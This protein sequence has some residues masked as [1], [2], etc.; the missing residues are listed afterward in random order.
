MADKPYEASAFEFARLAIGS[1]IT[2]C[3]GALI[4]LMAYAG[5]QQDL[6]PPAVEMLG[7]AA[8]WLGA[9][10]LLALLT[11]LLSYVNQ[12]FLAWGPPQPYIRWIAVAAG[13]ASLVSLG[14]G[15]LTA[16]KMVLIAHQSGG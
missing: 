15:G 9:S 4:A 1:T 10:L 5:Q 16:L 13:V 11:A 14:I 7:V 3:G 6:P 2:S 8:A 12:A